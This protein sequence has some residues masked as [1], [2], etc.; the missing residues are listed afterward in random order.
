M[1]S[2][3]LIRSGALCAIVAAV[4]G[5]LG[6]LHHVT[7]DRVEESLLFKA[8]GVLLMTAL[9]LAVVGLFGVTLFHADRWHALGKA[10][11][12]IALFGTILIAGDIYYETIV[13]PHIA[14]VAPRFLDADLEGW[15]LLGVV[16]SFALFGGGWLLVGIAVARARLLTRAGAIIL[17]IGGLIGFTPLP[18]SYLVFFVGLA[19]LG[20]SMKRELA[21]AS[22]VRHVDSLSREEAS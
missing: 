18:G 1:T 13:T 10:A 19:M 20:L 14:D 16:V 8:H 17:S 3:S 22:H 2:S 5:I 21:M 11:F 12:W 7:S 6:D 4:L 9:V 15:H